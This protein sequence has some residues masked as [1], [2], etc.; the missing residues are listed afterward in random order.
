MSPKGI[1]STVSKSDNL[2]S[3]TSRNEIN[4]DTILLESN[5]FSLFSG[6]MKAC[7][8]KTTWCN[9]ARSR[10]FFSERVVRLTTD[11]LEREVWISHLEITS[12]ADIEQ[13]SSLVEPRV[14]VGHFHIA[15][16]AVSSDESG[17]AKLEKMDFST[18][19]KYRISETGRFSLLAPARPA[20]TKNQVFESFLY[21]REK[22]TFHEY[23]LQSTD[24]IGKRR[25]K[26]ATAP[27]V[28]DEAFETPISASSHGRG[29]S[30]PYFEFFIGMAANIID[31][32]RSMND[33]GHKCKG[34]LYFRRCNVTTKRLC[35]TTRCSCSMG[36]D[37][38]L[39][40][41]GL[42]K[43]Q[44]TSDIKISPQKSVPVPDVLYALGVCLTPN[45]MAHADQLFSAMLLT[46]PSRNLLKEIIKFVV[47]PYLIRE[48]ERI[49]GEA[50][51]NIRVSG[52]SPVLCMDVGHSSARNSQAATLAA[53]SGNVLL[54]TLTDTKTNAWLKE[55]AL[56]ERALDFAIMEEKLDVCMI[57]IDDNAKNAS[58]I[59]SYKRVNGPPQCRDET[60]K[61]GIDVFH[62]AKAMGKHVIKITSENL[63]VMEK[64]FKPLCQKDCD[65][66]LVGASINEMILIKSNNYFND[67]LSTFSTYGATAWREASETPA[68]MKDFA[69]KNNLIDLT[70]NYSY[71][72]P[73]VTAW[74]SIML[75]KPP[76][77][78]IS[79]VKITLS[80]S[81]KSL[82]ILAISVEGVTGNIRADVIKNEKQEFYSY[83]TKN[84]PDICNR[85]NILSVDLC[86][87]TK[88]L[89]DTL[90]H[91]PMNVEVVHITPEEAVMAKVFGSNN[92]SVKEL[93]KLSVEKI[94]ILGRHL[95][96]KMEVPV[97]DKTAKMRSFC[98][99]NLWRIN[100]VWEDVKEALHIAQRAFVSRLGEFKRTMKNLLR[101]VNDQFGGWSMK[102]KMCFLINGLLNYVN[103]YSD[104]HRDCARYFWW[105]QCGDSHVKYVPTQDY[106][107]VIS[108]GRGTGCR[109]L[110]PVFFR[111]FVT[112]FVISKYAETQ[113][114]KC[115]CFSKTTICES[116]FHWKSIM[117]PKWQN[118]PAEEYERKER[119]AFIAF[120]NRQNEKIF[121]LKKLVK[122]KY[123]NTLT[124]ASAQKNSRYERHILDAIADICGSSPAVIAAVE[125]FFQ[126]CS[127]RQERRRKLLLS[128]TAQYEADETAK[129][130]NLG[131]VVHELRTLHSSGGPT[132]QSFKES[133][134]SA[135]PV[136][137]FPFL[138]E[139]LLND[140]QKYRLE[141]VWASS[142]ALKRHRQENDVD[143]LDSDVLSGLCT[144]CKLEINVDKIECSLCSLVVHT[145]CFENYNTEWDI[146]EGVSTCKECS[147]FN[148]LASATSN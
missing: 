10:H 22:L 112:S 54:F 77:T 11:L 93:R 103:H 86:E 41:S 100:N 56:V 141:K 13:L 12:P 133:A 20:A 142:R 30:I 14:W 15:D 113:F 6:K 119:A 72:Q 131:P 82:R 34:S 106:C 78:S 24:L 5:S 70:D 144:Y 96:D 126:K 125:H 33:H 116:Y 57:E 98:V 114:W 88:E 3:D 2:L 130:L 132:T 81:L 38:K 89:E 48:K 65:A 129:N 147:N 44:S 134:S 139:P 85:G 145:D 140:D 42:F 29:L 27:E 28:K 128:V 138:N 123:A 102:F 135:R 62:A 60:V 105:T 16:F 122:S 115:L 8:C 137:P 146:S 92:R 25:R 19:T 58:I 39:W 90:K 47:D 87:I 51:R 68:S 120:V 121:L 104:D 108:S 136:S 110:I 69:D 1:V 74:N 124:V 7:I 71:W 31:L 45:T 95:A 79:K 64:F 99:C 63:A 37:C 94:T 35:L 52:V 50:C 109:D 9:E 40:D 18:V 101:V 66:S 91:S 59:T 117:I 36:K 21:G 83:L 61:A 76:I 46:P 26:R 127:T 143:V 148:R 67:I 55:T 53:A 23:S 75:G 4:V 118:I 80:L 84:L 43:W 107:T 111:L 97:P 49:V 32:M 17:N 73:V